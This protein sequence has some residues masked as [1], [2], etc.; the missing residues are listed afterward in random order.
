M[1]SPAL[2]APGMLTV[3]GSA[4]PDHREFDHSVTGAAADRE[5]LTPI[6]SVWMF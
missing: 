6:K 4:P 1:A 3:P 2:C 5:T